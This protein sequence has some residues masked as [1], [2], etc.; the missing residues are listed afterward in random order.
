MAEKL[1]KA[2]RKTFTEQQD[3][4]EEDVVIVVST[5]GRNPVPIDSVLIAKKR[6]ICYRD[7]ITN[8]R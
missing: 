4:R 6:C 1:L 3:I 8:I 2:K 5:S 7:I